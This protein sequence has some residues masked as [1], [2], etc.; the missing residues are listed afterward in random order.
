[1]LNWNTGDNC[2]TCLQNA[3]CQQQCV[4]KCKITSMYFRQQQ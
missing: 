3:P 1:M 4:G 2:R